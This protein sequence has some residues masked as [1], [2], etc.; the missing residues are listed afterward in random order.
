MLAPHY[1]VIV[2]DLLGFGFSDKPDIAYNLAQHGA[3][4][5]QIVNAARIST[6]AG[7]IGHSCG[8]VIAV[9][10]L[11]ANPALCTRLVLAATPLVSPRFPIRQE[12]LRHPRDRAMLTWPPLAQAVHSSIHLLWPLL[13]H[14][15][16]AAEL[17][18]ARAGY[19]EHTIASYVRTAEQCLFQANID[20]AI[21]QLQE[22]QV[23]LLY[24]QHDTT[25]P[26]VHAE[27]MLQAFP[28]SRLEMLHDGHYAVLTEGRMPLIN[29]LAL[30]H[31]ESSI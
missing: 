30:A 9:S 29:W 15:P 19:L 26:S 18:G 10:L 20:P 1:R 13:Q 4:V 5:A 24:G 17:Q 14:L 2:P 25:I 31:Q 11:A 16:V 21:T 6:L 3:A 28:N 23:L 8:G 12:L 27:R 22:L 7:V